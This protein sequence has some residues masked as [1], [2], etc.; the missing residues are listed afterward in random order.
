MT[1]RTWVKK[2]VLKLI[3]CPKAMPVA[4]YQVSCMHCHAA[5]LALNR[6]QKEKDVHVR[7]FRMHICQAAKLVLN[8]CQKEKDAHVQLYRQNRHGKCRFEQMLNLTFILGMF[9]QFTQCFG[10]VFTDERLVYM[11]GVFVPGDKAT[12]PVFIANELQY[13]QRPEA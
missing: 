11:H 8:R 4:N 5:K 3:K 1:R 2:I 13:C 7:W 6:C 10:I 12:P 9:I